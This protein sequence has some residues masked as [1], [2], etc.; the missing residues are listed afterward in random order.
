MRTT[1]L[2]LGSGERAD[3]HKAETE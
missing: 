2:V 1:S 3:P